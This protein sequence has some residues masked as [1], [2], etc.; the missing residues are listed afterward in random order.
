VIDKLATAGWPENQKAIQELSS[1]EHRRMRAWVTAQQR[2][3]D[4]YHY[5][6]Q[7]GLIDEE[8]WDN[9]IVPAIRIVAPMW[10]TLEVGGLRPSFES[11]VNHLLDGREK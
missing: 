7:Q 4:N 2:Q 9:V 8:Y 5:Q 10:Q 1:L 3:L 6:Y 11:T